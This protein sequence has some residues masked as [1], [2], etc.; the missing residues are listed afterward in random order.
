[1]MLGIVVGTFVCGQITLRLRSYKTPVIA[2]SVL[3]TIG[4]ILFARMNAST[5]FSEVIVAMIAAGFGMG[6]MMPGYT[7]AVQNAAPQRY[8]GIATASSTFFR[9]IGSTVGVA[10]FGS[11]L[12]TRYH[13]DFANAVPH[14]IPQ[15]AV[16]AFSNPLLLSQMRP[17]LEATFSRLNNGPHVLETL[18]ASV[19]PALLGGIQWIF[20]I[21]AVLMV[22][23][24]GLNLMMKDVP[25]RHGPV[26]SSEPS[27]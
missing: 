27:A 11:L 6:L 22:A 9:S 7:V 19:A 15:E 3:I 13:H 1:M 18:Y 5:T 26:T 4:T 12:L 2:G 14:D 10:V 17:Q 24:F 16:A 23:L 8:M 25:L 20:L 21:S